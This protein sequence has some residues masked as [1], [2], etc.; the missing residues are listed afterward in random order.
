M[1]MMHKEITDDCIEHVV[2]H[3]SVKIL[4]HPLTPWV[5]SKVKYLN[6]A[7]TKSVDNIFYQ[8]FAC[9]QRNKRLKH[10]RWDLSFKPWIRSPGRSLGVGPEAEIHFFRNMIMLRISN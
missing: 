2:K 7:I 1:L 6:F 8:N 10:I 5:G 9:R 3:D 4:T